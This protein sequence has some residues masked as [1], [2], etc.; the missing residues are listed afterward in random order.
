MKH[1]HHHHPMATDLGSF[2]A[3]FIDSD[4]NQ[5]TDVVEINFADATEKNIS[6]LL[7]TLL[8]RDREEFTP[9]RFRIHIPGKDLIIDQYPNDLLS[10]LQKHGVTNPF[11]TTITLSAEP[12]A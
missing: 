3:N 7:N 11:E 12:Q 2:K 9:Y 10:L 5:M 1:H 8:G 4:G 6:N